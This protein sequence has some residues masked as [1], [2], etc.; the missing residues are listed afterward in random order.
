MID[1]PDI[2]IVQ[3]SS[4]PFYSSPYMGTLT[5]HDGTVRIEETEESIPVEMLGE[6]NPI[7]WASMVHLYQDELGDNGD[8]TLEFRFRSMGDCWFGLMR[9][10]VRVDDVIVRIYDTRM[11]HEYGSSVILREFSAR[12]ETYDNLRQK[13]F[14]FTP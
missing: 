8:T 13:G 6:D 11:F 1:N 5:D 4:D 12:E 2:K 10:Y 3:R 14:Q 9:N 7:Q